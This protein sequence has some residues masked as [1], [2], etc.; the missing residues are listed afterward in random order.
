VGEGIDQVGLQVS[1]G[2]EHVGLPTGQA[3]IS[4]AWHRL[5][6]VAPRWPWVTGGLL[7]QLCGAA[8]P[9]VYVLNKAHHEDVGG[10][11]TRATLTLAWRQAVHSHTGLYLMIAGAAVFVAGS[12][13]MAR[14]FVKSWVTLFVAVPIAAL[15]GVLVLGAAAIVIGLLAIGL[16][17][18]FDFGGGG[19]GGGSSAAADTAVDFTPGTH[20]SGTLSRRR[21]PD[22]EREQEDSGP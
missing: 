6:P 11:I 4:P 2:I 16:D 8:A 18:L 13:V 12:M 9:I 10:Q 22:E 17:D 20:D 1:E 19:G 14:P 15:A 7:L 5:K 21:R 3:P